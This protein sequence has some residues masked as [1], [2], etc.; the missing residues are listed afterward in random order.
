MR[1]SETDCGHFMQVFIMIE[2]TKLPET[3]CV[4]PKAKE[5]VT[6]GSRLMIIDIRLREHLFSGSLCDLHLLAVTGGKERTESQFIALL[7]DTGFMFEQK[8][9]TPT[10]PSIII[11]RA[12]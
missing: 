11:G 2:T 3:S 7:E 1:C 5:A 6:D 8:I 4:V 12:K 9:T 10:L